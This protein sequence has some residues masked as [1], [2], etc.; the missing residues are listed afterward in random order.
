[1]IDN[2]GKG[3]KIV[4]VYA[5]TGTGLLLF[6]RRMEIFLGTSRCLVFMGD[7]NTNSDARVDWVGL[8]DKK[9]RRA[10]FANLLSRLR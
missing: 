9:S 2:E 1:M 3:F 6:F 10:R 4:A 7:L 5:T 8:A